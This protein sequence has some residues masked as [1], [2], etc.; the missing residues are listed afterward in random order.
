VNVIRSKIE[1]TTLFFKLKHT[2]DRKNHG[3]KG[4][5]TELD[6]RS[7]MTDGDSIFLSSGKSRDHEDGK[8]NGNARKLYFRKMSLRSKQ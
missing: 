2:S 3:E 6:G 4:S 1:G 8:W 5:N 7:P